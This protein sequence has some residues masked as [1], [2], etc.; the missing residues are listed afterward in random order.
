MCTVCTATSGY[1]CGRDYTTPCPIGE[2][3]KDYFET[4]NEPLAIAYR[5]RMATK[6]IAEKGDKE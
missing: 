6:A 5:K 1:G 3:L 4:S 2:V